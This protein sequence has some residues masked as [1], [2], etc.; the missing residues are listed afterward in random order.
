MAIYPSVW[1]GY[2]EELTI[3]QALEQLSLAGFAHTELCVD[4]AEQLLERGTPEKV[5]AQLAEFAADL[6]MSS[7]QGHLTFE[8]G[9]CDPEA[10]EYLKRE[11]DLFAAVGIRNAVL[12]FSG[13]SGLSPEAKMEKRMEGL[14]VLADHVKGSDV[15]LCLENLHGTSQT[16]T[17]EQINSII[18]AIGGENLGICLDTGHLH[19]VNGLGQ[20][21]QTQRE[22][23]LA[24]G[25]RL[26]ALH[27]TENNGKNDVHQMPYSARYGIDW[28][29]VVAAL[30]QVGYQGL[31]NL[32]ILGECNAPYP[33]KAAK[34]RFIREMTRYMLEN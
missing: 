10:L 7:S 11:L 28:P 24:A 14:R 27:I 1:T 4:H 31:F 5:G 21:N 9:L 2:F 23:I 32:E 19:M 6:G 33:I 25:K 13:G 16:Y 8:K 34:L 29:D 3:E 15:I 26:H 12:H 20:A 18:D 17:V 22:F 30:R